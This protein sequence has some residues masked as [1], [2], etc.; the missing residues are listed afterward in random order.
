MLSGCA[1]KPTEVLS[2]REYYEKAKSALTSG[3]FTEATEQLE[4]LETYHPFGRYAEQAQLDLIYARYNALDTEGAAAAADR[5]IKLHPDSINV[6]YAYYIKGLASYYAD[7]GMAVRFLPVDP[8]SRDAGRAREA[9]QAF[10]AL[11]SQYP[12]SSYAPD[13]EQRMIA[14]RNHLADYELHVA[15]YYIRREAYLAAVNRAQYVVENYPET[16][17]VADALALMVELYRELGMTAQATDALMILAANYPEHRSLDG[18]LRFVGGM[19]VKEDR[20]LDRIFDI[21][22]DD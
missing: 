3:N 16:P 8:T 14:I 11:V 4:A 17:A 13:A 2:E 6:D 20:G 9:Y 12:D 21:G 22:L 1:S 10:S 5:F 18:D 19:V 7:I 15:N